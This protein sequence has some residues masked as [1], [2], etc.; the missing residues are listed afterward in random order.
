MP[1]EVQLVIEP[2]S[3]RLADIL[4][5]KLERRMAFERRERLGVA[6]RGSGEAAARSVVLLW[7]SRPWD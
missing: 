1:A 5:V 3:V 7:D 6:V 2:Q 4:L